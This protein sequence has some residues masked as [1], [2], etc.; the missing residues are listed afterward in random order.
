MNIMKKKI[1]YLFQIHQRDF[2]KHSRPVSVTVID[3]FISYTI[4]YW[5]HNVENNWRWMGWQRHGK[6]LLRMA[7]LVGV[8][9]CLSVVPGVAQNPSNPSNI[10]QRTAEYDKLWQDPEVEQRIRNG[11]QANRMGWVTFRFVDE[12]GAPL[13][14]V[15]VE[16]EQ[17]RHDFRFGCNLFK[18]QAFPT[19][20]EN[21]LYEERFC[22]LFNFAYLP[23]FWSDLEPEQGKPRYTKNSPPIF[24]RPPPD[25][26][27][28][29]CEQHG[30]T[31]KGHILMWHQ[32][33]PKWLP[34]DRNEIKR[35][36]IK[37]FNEL[38]ARYG[39]RIKYW[40]LVEE[41]LIRPPS[42]MVP[43]DYM[44]TVLQAADRAFPESS[45]FSIG[46][47]VGSSFIDFHG[48][49]SPF[50]CMLQALQLRK[51][52][53]DVIEMQ[54]NMMYVSKQQYNPAFN[55]LNFF[56]ILDQYS[57]FGRPLEIDQ[58][59]VTGLPAG[60]KGEEDQAVAVRNIYRLCFSHPSVESIGWWNLDDG[61]QHMSEGDWLPGLLRA[62]LSPKPAYL[63]LQ[64]LIRQEWWTRLSLNSGSSEVVKVQGFYGWYKLTA[65]HDGKVIQRDIHLTKQGSNRYDII[66]R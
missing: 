33:L 63:A 66:L 31:P 59:Q 20:E 60:P 26:T 52:R 50:Y 37:R 58:I 32:F 13:T 34:Q 54:G 24:R 53:F 56:A 17:T 22:D 19:P 25:V 15:E 28:E 3:I 51:A 49:S 61:K 48:D 43:D 4:N 23:F 14:N 65:K 12:A 36:M 41:S 16:F 38:A 39:Q 7:L 29:F 5:L 45:V 62:D 57:D 46:E 35:L 2:S 8:W 30:I 21:K 10:G 40:D 44:Y 55:P 11:I 6:A 27:L 9:A 18:L 42:V 47:T 64:K 1:L